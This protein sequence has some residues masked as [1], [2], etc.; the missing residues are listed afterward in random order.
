MDAAEQAK[1]NAHW[2][3]RKITLITS[4]S[5]FVLIG[6]V[7]AAVV[8][9]SVANDGKNDSGANAQPLSTSLKAMCD[10]TLYKD[11]WFSSL[12]LRANDSRLIRPEDLFRMSIEVAIWQ[13][14]R[15]TFQS[16]VIFTIPRLAI[17]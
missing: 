14:L 8:G 7:V 16:E 15:T 12:S 11:A 5:S 3:T 9:T 10:V 4:L 2:R 1:L 6:V 17:R 13:R